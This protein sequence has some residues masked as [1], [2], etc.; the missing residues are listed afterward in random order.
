MVIFGIN[1]PKRVYPLNRFLQ[2]VVRRRESQ[3]CTLTPDFTIVILKM[4]TSGLKI[5]RNGNFWYKFTPKGAYPLFD[6]YKIW[7]G[8]GVPGLHVQAKFDHCSFKNVALRFQK[9]PKMVIFGK[10]L[11]LGG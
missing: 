8:D 1:C 5:A 9:S 6:L 2:N 10:N 3:V 4:W 7:P 11:P